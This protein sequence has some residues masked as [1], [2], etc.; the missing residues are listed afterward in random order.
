LAPDS[1]GYLIAFNENN[2]SPLQT[3]II[4]R[5]RVTISPGGVDDD[6]VAYSHLI[7]IN[8]LGDNIRALAAFADDVVKVK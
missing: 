6:Y 5:H 2:R 7:D 3:V 1:L 4:H 8:R